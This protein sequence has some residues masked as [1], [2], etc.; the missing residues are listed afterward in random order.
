M[1]YN[2]I[3]ITTLDDITTLGNMNAVTGY[4]HL[5]LVIGVVVVI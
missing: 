3:M 1:E 2:S 4:S 5:V